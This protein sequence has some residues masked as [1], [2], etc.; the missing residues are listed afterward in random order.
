MTCSPLPSGCHFFA[1]FLN[2]VLVLRIL[3]TLH[4]DCALPSLRVLLRHCVLLFMALQVLED[5][6]HHCLDDHDFKVNRLLNKHP[7]ASL[8]SAR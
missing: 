7:F 3:S 6:M 8:P 5:L 2:C 1:S 4:F